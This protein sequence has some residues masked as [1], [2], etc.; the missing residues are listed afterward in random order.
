MK[1]FASDSGLSA[2]FSNAYDQYIGDHY[3]HNK[4]LIKLKETAVKLPFKSDYP[5][6]IND[7]INLCS[8]QVH[9]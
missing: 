1:T 4:T 3:G 5:D 9:E 2:L 6:V 7:D 8:R